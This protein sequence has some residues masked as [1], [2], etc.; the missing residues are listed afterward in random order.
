MYIE[1]FYNH[2]EL[3]DFYISRDLEF[4]ETKQY[5]HPPLFS[6]VAKIDDLIVGAIT[7][8]QENEDF[9]LD[10]LAV[11]PEYENQRIGTSLFDISIN[12]IKEQYGNRKIYLVAKIPDFWEKKGF[13]IIQRDEAPG[14][15]ECFTCE[16]FQKTCFPE[17]M[18]LDLGK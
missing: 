14:F 9:I 16:D 5:F 17:I 6:Y 13:R 1:E 11:S 8:C 18:V 10:E 15:S 3:V 7:I 4:N 12:R 2:N